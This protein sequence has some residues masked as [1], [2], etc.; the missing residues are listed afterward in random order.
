MS[1]V[2]GDPTGCVVEAQEVAAW[3]AGT[4]ETMLQARCLNLTASLSCLVDPNAGE[5][6]IS[7]AARLAEASGDAW[8]IA[9]VGRATA[10]CAVLRGDWRQAEARVA[11]VETL[12][13]CT[14]VDP[15]FLTA[16]RSYTALM[17]CDFEGAVRAGRAAQQLAVDE[18]TGLTLGT[19]I[20]VF[21]LVELGRLTEA[22]MALS[23]GEAR[24]DRRPGP[25]S[26]EQLNVARGTILLWKG[27]Y[28]GATAVLEPLRE[29]LTSL[30]IAVLTEHVALYLAAAYRLLGELDLAATRAQE[31][32]ALSRR[33]GAR[34]QEAAALLQQAQLAVIGGEDQKGERLAH[35]ALTKA[36]EVANR[37]WT[38]AA[39]EVLGCLA[40]RGASH[41]EG[42][43][44]LASADV[45]RAALGLT[46][47]PLDIDV[48]D[49]TETVRG[50]LPDDTFTTMWTQGTEMSIDKAIAYC[51]RARGER[52]RPSAGWDSLTPT[53]M[54]VVELVALGLTNPQIGERL[55]IG[56][57]TVKTHLAHVFSKLGISHRSE[58]AAQVTRRAT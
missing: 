34:R 7:D 36:S 9:D 1:W 55:F 4:G 19:V 58:L 49:A 28:T 39:L 53:E 38:V 57:G 25:L 33:T 40:I 48:H 6:I 29:M 52:A 41:A 47:G 54:Q 50:E 10:L 30:G 26:S 42:L 43:R 3:A 13:A 18:S 14:D 11:H 27:D 37:Q 2:M 17:R 44:L 5:A 46:R 56:R 31:A 20:L 51:R 45:G 22:E 21:A 8:T 24:L 35:E 12:A 23:D 16:L 15:C 32:A